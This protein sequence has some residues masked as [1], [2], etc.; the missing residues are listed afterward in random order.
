MAGSLKAR[1][2]KLLGTLEETQRQE[3]MESERLMLGKYQLDT[4]RQ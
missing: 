3:R 2:E 1:S 4:S